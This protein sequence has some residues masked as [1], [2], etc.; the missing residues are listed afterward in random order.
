[1]KTLIRFLI[2]LFLAVAV[3]STATAR[4]ASALTGEA[5]LL[6]SEL[7][8]AKKPI[9]Y[10]IFDLGGKEV[11]LKSRGVTLRE[12]KIEDMRFWGRPVEVV[13][14]PMVKKS[15]LFKEPK[16]I[17]IDP[18]KNKEEETTET[19]PPANTPSTAFD[20]E[21]LELKDMPANYYLQ[22][23]EGIFITVRPKAT[24]TGSKLYNIA[25]YAGWYI[26]RPL[27]TIWHSIKG[28][29]FTSIYLVLNAEDAR[30][31]YWS[32]VENSENIIHQQ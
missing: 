12:M 13:P 19:P 11:L 25:S 9:I 30:S 17:S 2:S 5:R 20:I 14:R 15:A 32:L 21:A 4:D 22:F 28:R 1:M 3:C 18:N 6:E 7:S 31:V 24:T 10:F 23:S 29:P 26:S 27:L 8:L 16:R